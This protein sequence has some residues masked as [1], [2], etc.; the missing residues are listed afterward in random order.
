M[1]VLAKPLPSGFIL[2]ATIVAGGVSGYTLAGG[3]KTLTVDET[4]TLSNK[5][6]INTANIYSN[7]APMQTP[8]ESWI[9]PSS[10]AG[11]YFKGDNVGIGTT[12]PQ[13]DLEVVNSLGVINPAVGGHARMMLGGTTGAYLDFSY[14]NN[15]YNANSWL[16]SNTLLSDA[17]SFYQFSR[18]S[19][20]MVIKND[21]NVGIG[22]YPVIS[23]TGKLDM[24]GDTMRLRTARTPASAGAAGNQGEI[25]W[26]ADYIYVA[27]NTNTWKRTPISTWA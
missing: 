20:R 2:T 11:I 14:G 5:A 16:L 3:G 22:I 23:G 12:T 26:D 10:T 19:H 15:V 21:G 4:A 18:S 17:F 25:C 7:I 8:A 9:G 1:N 13:Y 6:N 24:N 27:V